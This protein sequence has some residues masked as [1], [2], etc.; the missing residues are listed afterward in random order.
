MPKFQKVR[1]NPPRFAKF[2][3]MGSCFYCTDVDKPKFVRVLSGN[4]KGSKKAIKGGGPTSG[5]CDHPGSPSGSPSSPSI[6]PKIEVTP[7]HSPEA[8]EAQSTGSGSERCH[9]HSSS[10]CLSSH[11]EPI[12]AEFFEL[13]EPDHLPALEELTGLATLPEL[14]SFADFEELNDTLELPECPSWD[15]V[16]EPTAGTG[17]EWWEVLLEGIGI[18]PLVQPPYNEEHP[19]AMEDIPDEAS[20]GGEVR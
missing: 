15:V 11:E 20:S 1:Q 18:V 16:Q 2:R 12:P 13:E 3:G 8:Q 14:P 6:N 7:Q 10:G 19:Y 17:E 5:R 9:E 4:R